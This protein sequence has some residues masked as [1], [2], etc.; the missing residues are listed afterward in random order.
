MKLNE[1]DLINKGFVRQ[2]DGSWAKRP[3]P[4]G[5]VEV[6]VRKPDSPQALDNGNATRKERPKSVVICLVRVGKRFI[7]S[8]NF[9]GG[10]KPLRDAIASSLGVDDGSECLE[11]EYEQVRTRGPEGVIVLISTK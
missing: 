1:Q 4:V 5:A 7:D 10:A 6:P 3:V 9:A 11:W 8:D 2:V